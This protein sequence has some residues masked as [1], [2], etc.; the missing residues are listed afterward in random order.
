MLH[1]KESWTR[2][3]NMV[4]N[5]FSLLRCCDICFPSASGFWGKLMWRVVAAAALR[6]TVW[7]WQSLRWI[8][9][10]FLSLLRS[11][12]VLCGTPLL[13]PAASSIYTSQQNTQHPSNLASSAEG[14]CRPWSE[15]PC[16]PSQSAFISSFKNWV[17]ILMPLLGRIDSVDEFSHYLK[18]P[19]V[20]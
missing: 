11:R 13:I 20:D 17:E 16:R 9:R 10:L 3:G 6:V 12:S 7:L 15:T 5:Q 14:F 19:V 18:S 2:D 8:W 4:G 1:I